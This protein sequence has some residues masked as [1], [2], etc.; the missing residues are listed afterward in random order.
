MGISNKAKP[1]SRTRPAV[2]K[3]LELSQSDLAHAP[4]T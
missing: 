1:F 2:L 4:P 3:G